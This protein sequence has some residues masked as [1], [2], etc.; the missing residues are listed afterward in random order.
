MLARHWSHLLPRVSS[1]DIEDK[2]KA[3][4]IAKI[5]LCVQ[6]TWFCV[7]TIY[8][9]AT[10]F[11]VSLLEL[12]TFGHAICALITYVIWWD[13]PFDLREPFILSDQN[14]LTPVVLLYMA[15]A[16]RSLN[17]RRCKLVDP[18]NSS[19][20]SLPST[21]HGPSVHRVY[22]SEHDL[23]E[24]VPEHNY[25]CDPSSQDILSE[26]SIHKSSIESG[27][28]DDSNNLSGHDGIFSHGVQDDLSDHNV[29]VDHNDSSDITPANTQEQ[30]SNSMHK[31]TVKTILPNNEF[32]GA[33]FKSDDD[34]PAHLEAE[35]VEMWEHLSTTY[36]QLSIEIQSSVYSITNRRYRQK[37]LFQ[38]RIR[39]SDGLTEKFS[40]TDQEDDVL[41]RTVLAVTSIF[42]GGLHIAA[43]TADFPSHAEK[44]LWQ[45]S[46]VI[47]MGSF[48]TVLLKFVSPRG[49]LNS[50]VKP[51]LGK[52]L[53]KRPIVPKRI[54][55]SRHVSAFGNTILTLII[56][57]Y[58]LARGY[59]VIESFVQL[60]RLPRRAFETPEWTQYVPHI[61]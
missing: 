39:N 38:S 32:P 17:G 49:I 13:K 5:L 25:P 34:S 16:K 14:D 30:N 54:R 3:N 23:H 18:V 45:M 43:W 21:M 51:F 28:A 33:I 24:I 60:F 36:K 56:T 59:L 26:S 40:F 58:C 11:A 29:L 12:N 41:F 35:E 10:G 57:A 46:G 20:I 2:S 15:S 53:I 47:V 7:Q 31:E 6:A 61:T 37:R 8:R 22:G 27:E 4:D 1:E 44:L 52:P 42:Y 9:M 48:P 55:R 19:G 50:L